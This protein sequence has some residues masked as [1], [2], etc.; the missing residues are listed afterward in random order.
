MVH[1]SREV[2][3]SKQ[4]ILVEISESLAEVAGEIDKIRR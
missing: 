1:E 4:A 2:I 3:V